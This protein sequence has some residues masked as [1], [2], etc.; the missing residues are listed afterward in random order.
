MS[1]KEKKLK[2]LVQY[3]L[4]KYNKI[5]VLVNNAGIDQQKLF[6]DITDEDWQ[7]VINTNLTLPFV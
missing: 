5:D 6:Q 1:Q 2:Q 4:R 7:K 3:T